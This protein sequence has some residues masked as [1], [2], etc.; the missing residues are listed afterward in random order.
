M[1]DEIAA[2][3]IATEVSDKTKDSAGKQGVQSHA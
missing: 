2:D 3:A 1:P